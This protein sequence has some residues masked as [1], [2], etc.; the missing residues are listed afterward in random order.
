MS[1]D[2]QDIRQTI[3]RCR[4]LGRAIPDPEVSARLCQMAD[5][6]Q[7]SLDS[8]AAGPGAGDIELMRGSAVR[9]GA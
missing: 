8:G 7:R 4:R 1:R 9:G 2:I 3:E 6:L 5:D